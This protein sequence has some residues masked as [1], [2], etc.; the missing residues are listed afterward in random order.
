MGAQ[1]SNLNIDENDIRRM[2]THPDCE[3]R[4][5]LTQKVCR[6]INAVELTALEQKTVSAILAF[7][8]KDSATMVRRA[9]AI[10][11]KKSK[12]LP[13]EIAQKLIRDVDSIVSPVLIH[14]PVLTDADLI[15]ILKSKAAS[16]I[17]AISKRERIKGDLVKPIIRFGDSRAVASVAANDGA[18]I[19]THLGDQLLDIYHDNDLVKKSLI[20]RRDLPA[21]IVEKLITMV[22]AEMAVRLHQNH[23]IPVNVAINI[24]NQSRERASIDFISQYWVSRGLT[25]LINRLEREDRLTSSMIVRAA[26]CGQIPMVERTLAKKSGVSLSK[27]S[28]MVHD[29]GPFGLKTLCTQSGLSDRDF[30]IIRA[31]IAIFRD[32]E[33]KGRQLSREKFQK[34]MLERILSL[35]MAFPDEDLDYLFDKLDSIESH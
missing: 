3:V 12:N 18:E 4:A 24:A 32:M 1:P 31:A 27:A 34:A 15:D 30:S 28:L 23:K 21:P 26:C 10:T 22:N 7:I 19:G 35:P 20:A 29:R 6:Q 33:L 25:I 14:S 11:L 16:K 13:R 17:M 9:L 2:V 5:V 8:V